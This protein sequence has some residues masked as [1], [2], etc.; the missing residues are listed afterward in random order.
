MSYERARRRMV[1]MLLAY[2]GRILNPESLVHEVYDS[3]TSM[4]LKRALVE[5]FARIVT[6][7]PEALPYDEFLDSPYWIG[8]SEFLKNS[9]GWRCER[10]GRH[11]QESPLEVHHKT[12]VHRGH[13]FPDH[14]DDLEVLCNHCHR[15]QHGHR[16]RGRR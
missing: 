11:H 4:R 12:Y 9:A 10:C 14:L 7:A 15:K 3:E 13:E 16:P 2:E 8:L 6:T 5:R 1:D